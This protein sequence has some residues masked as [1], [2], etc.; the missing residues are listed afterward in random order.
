M[1]PLL[2]Q[3]GLPFAPFSVTGEVAI[4]AAGP[5]TNLYEALVEGGVVTHR[6][7]GGSGDHGDAVLDR[8]VAEAS[9]GLGLRFYG[10]AAAFDALPETDLELRPTG[11]Q[12]LAYL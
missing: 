6:L 3:P 8:V 2:D 7:P 12:E 5:D 9:E 4:H 1:E 11:P 10:D